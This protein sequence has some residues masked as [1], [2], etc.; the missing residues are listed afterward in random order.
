[1]KR[2]IILFM[3]LGS[4]SLMAQNYYPQVVS[5]PVT[6]FMQLQQENPYILSL[7][8][9]GAEWTPS[10]RYV[11]EMAPNIDYTGSSITSSW[12]NGTWT[13][14]ELTTDSFI[15][16]NQNRLSVVFN[17]R[18]FDYPGYSNKSKSKYVFTYNTSNQL[19][20]FDYF[21]ATSI[22]SN[23][24]QKAGETY[25]TYDANG[26][27][28]LDSN[29]YYYNGTSQTTVSHY[30]YTGTKLNTIIQFNGADT[31]RI[32]YYTFTGDLL[33]AATSIEFD[34]NADEW[35]TTYADTFEYNLMN[36]VTRHSSLGYVFRDGT[37]SIE[38]TINES[39]SYTSNGRL[40]EEIGRQWVGGVWVNSTKTIITYD[41]NNKP[42][43]GYEYEYI[44]ND[45]SIAPRTKYLFNLQSGLRSV[46]NPLSEVVIAPNPANDFVTI[47]LSTHMANIQLF[48]VTG[49]C[50]YQQSEAIGEHK[51]DISSL[52]TGVYYATIQSEG[53]QRT[54]KIIV[55]H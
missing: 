22:T 6:G 53:S 13:D 31:A 27:Q 54:S 26:K 48:D 55:S 52:N 19:E 14:L 10:M 24:Y 5:T 47:D 17:K 40:K 38:P 51:I 12:Q 4:F 41:A 46:S 21:E 28:I 45:W 50:V 23:N 29:I 20:R 49:K 11:Q 8:R 37:L 43:E 2:T 16:D 42:I 9:D 44:A 3:L 25:Y 7:T 39:Y 32:T 15:L 35:T 1:M 30:T 33:A 36:Q 18:I 34:A